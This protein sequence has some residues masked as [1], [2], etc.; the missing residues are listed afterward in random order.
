V[1]FLPWRR[2]IL[3]ILVVALSTQP[4]FLLGA[5]FLQLEADIGLT[6]TTLGVL[7]AV[8]F[9]TASLSS[10][11]FG[12]LVERIGWR[13]AM[14]INAAVAA[15]VLLAI[16]A[17]GR[18]IGVIAG[19][20]VVGGIAYGFANPAANKA[21]AERVDPGRRG[22][23]FG[24]KHAGIPTSTLLAGLALPALVLTVG[25]PATFAAAALLAP[26]VWL[27]IPDDGHEPAAISG[28]DE[29]AHGAAP[30]TFMQ[31]IGLATAAALATWA[32][33]SLSTFLVAAAVDAD[34]TE[35]NAGLLL[36]A[37]SLASI[38]A[39]ISAGATNDRYRGRGFGALVVLL[40]LGSMVFLALR[41]TTGAGFVVLVVAAFATGWGWPGLMT[42]TVVNANVATAAASSGITQAGIFLGAGAGPVVLGWTIDQAGFGASWLLVA[43]ALAVAAVIVGGVGMRVRLRERLET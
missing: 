41:S 31:L 16:G 4:A 9:L 24:L 28:V 40:G 26:M 33:I 5:A 1:R 18:S 34:L 13:T 2:L 38:V 20:L 7:T 37:G 3:S 43:A 19:L 32:A 29:P 12:R 27:L 22:L 39:R 42:F 35:G 25:W 6:P 17:F 15:G 36:F 14:R 21:L 11:P 23:I 30:L 10:A 8:F